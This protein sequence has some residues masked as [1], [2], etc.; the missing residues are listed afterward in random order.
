MLT[1]FY[2]FITTV[3]T[4]VGIAEVIARQTIFPLMEVSQ[5]HVDG[6]AT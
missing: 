4:L 6:A 5:G 3:A 1:N 2:I